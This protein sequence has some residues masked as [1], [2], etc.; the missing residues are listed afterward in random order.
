MSDTPKSQP[1]TRSPASRRLRQA[2]TAGVIATLLLVV[3][4]GAVWRDAVRGAPPQVDGPVVAGWSQS[5]PSV[6]RL[7]LE[8][9]EETFEIARTETGWVMPSRGGYPVRPERIAALDAAL[10]ALTLERAMTR[11]PDKFDRLGLTDPSQGGQGVR[12]TVFDEA[13]AELTSFI[14][15]RERAD[16]LGLYVR[17]TGQVRTYAAR[18]SLPELADPGVWLGLSFW[19][20]DPSAVASADILPERGPRWAVQR[21]GVAQRNHELMSP[22][23][24]RL[25]TGGAANGVATAGTRIRFRDVKPASEIVGAFAASHAGVTF[26]GIAYR[27][28]FI[29]EDDARWAL[30]EVRAVTD[31]AEPRVERLQAYVEGWAFQVSDDAYERLTRPLD[32]V[33][34][35]RSVPVP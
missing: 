3:G 33:A 28:D 14:V 11:D 13:G 12:L 1:Q 5:A 27:F 8:T 25:I 22:N 24:W 7:R 31:D 21:A 6:A 20:V 18:G 35:R 15:G 30:I 34:E 29:A 9:S 10:G 2:I 19:D 17:E 32:Q 23:D 26:S 4:A 16:G